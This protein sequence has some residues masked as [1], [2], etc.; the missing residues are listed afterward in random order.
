MLMGYAKETFS[1]VGKIIPCSADDS[2]C[3]MR[4]AQKFP[5]IL[6]FS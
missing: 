1:I 4:V 6:E 5:Q 2:V 3:G